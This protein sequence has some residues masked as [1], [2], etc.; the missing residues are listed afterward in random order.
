MATICVSSCKPN[1]SV[2]DGADDSLKGPASVAQAA[3]VIDLSTFPLMNGASSVQRDVASLSYSVPGTAKAAYD[4]YRQQLAAQKWKESRDTSYTDQT[5]SGTFTRSGFV[6]SVSA[7]P[8]G[9]D[10]GKLAILIRN[11]GNVNLSKLPRPGGTKVVYA[12]DSAAMYVTEATVPATKEECRKLLTA[13][14]WQPYGM[15]GDTQWFKKNAVRVS[16]TVSSAPAQGGKTMISFGGE[17][18]SA[19]LPAPEDVQD[20]RYAD[21]TKELSF[22]SPAGKDAVVDFYKKALAPSGWE[23]TLQKL[24]DVDD[25]PTMIFRNPGKDMLTLSFSSERDGRLPVSLQFQSAAEIAELDRQ[26]KAK[27]PQIRAELERRQAQEDV[28][29]AEAHKPLSKVAV[30][31]PSDASGVEQSAGE[32]KF[33]IAKGKGKETARAWRKQF[34]ADGW[35]EDVAALEGMAGA[36]SLS[37]DKQSLTIRYTDT[38]FLPAEVTISARGAELEPAPTP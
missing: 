19:D 33:T 36:L 6:L 38:G 22:A 35:K 34:R 29:Y 26:L 37:K 4:F 18:M 25:R 1:G 16:T 13:D 17:M 12:G 27:A 9:G 5:A 20:L 7:Y 31:I 24:V 32:I 30:T 14:G 15:A 8:N 28:V 2:L 11:Q 21:T 23:S 10:D 3:H